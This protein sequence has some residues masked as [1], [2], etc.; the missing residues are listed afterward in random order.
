MGPTARISQRPTRTATGRSLAAR[1][2]SNRN[3]RM[4]ACTTPHGGRQRLAERRQSSATSATALRTYS[5]SSSECHAAVAPI[6]TCAGERNHRGRTEAPRR[7]RPP[8]RPSRFKAPRTFRVDAARDASEARSQEL[9]VGALREQRA[10]DGVAGASVASRARV[11]LVLVSASLGV[12]ALQRHAADADEVMHGYAAVP[13][14][15]LEHHRVV[16]RGAL[17]RVELLPP[18]ALPGR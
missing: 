2:E 3:A 7:P 5:T 1:R 4:A 15:A 18:L 10:L 14:P 9:A 8:A 13:V 6:E 17:P 11:Q 12:Q 16:A